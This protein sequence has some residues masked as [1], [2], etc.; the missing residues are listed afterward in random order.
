MSR[1]IMR[2]GSIEWNRKL[3]TLV[4]LRRQQLKIIGTN[5]IVDMKT[6]T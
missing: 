6:V 1:L 3:R 4:Q 2:T 5:K